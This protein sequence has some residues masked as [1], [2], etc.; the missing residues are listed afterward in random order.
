MKI[1]GYRFGSIKA[2]IKK[3]RLDLGIIYCENPSLCVASFT[4][5]LLK[6]N[7]IIVS[8]K[9]LLNT[10]YIK[11]IIV[12]SGCANTACG[13]NGVKD[14]EYICNTL[15]KKL[16]IKPYEILIASTGVI[17]E[18]LPT[19]KIISNLDKLVT[20]LSFN[21]TS[22]LN[23]AKSIMTTDTKPKIVYKTV[24]IKKKNFNILCFAKGSGMIAPDLAL[25]K[26]HATMLV[27]ILTDINFAKSLMLR[28][29]KKI[30]L[31]HFNSF[32]ID[33]DTSPNDTIFFVSSNSEENSEIDKK[34]IKKIED[35][36]IEISKEI[37]KKL[38]FDG[39]GVT[40]VVELEVC[41]CNDIDAKSIF[42]TI[43]TSLLVKTAIYGADPNWGRILSA[44]GRSGV[45]FDINKIDIWI[46]NYLV[47]KNGTS[48][49]VKDEYVRKTMS[50]NFY[51]IKIDLKMKSSKSHLFFIT[52]LS[53]KY[54]EINS[55]YKT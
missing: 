7:S 27:F 50:E 25:S 12:N 39:E 44:C 54:V 8:Q 34:D 21:K 32:S 6:S 11:C 15:A 20:S 22:I 38:L 31:P 5:N 42:K 2:G 51:R 35:I 9:H 23:F 55:M 45:N 17:G 53:K 28:L 3:D 36:F 18:P 41:N 26:N 40:K 37:I 47:V 1:K 49:F 30:I 19:N 16:A 4:K 43:S 24:N 48:N 52:D 29:M 10:D 13:K 46:G 33:G 14:T